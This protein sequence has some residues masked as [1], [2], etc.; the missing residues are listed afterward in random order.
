MISSSWRQLL[1]QVKLSDAEEK[2]VRNRAQSGVVIFFSIV[3]DRGI[4]SFEFRELRSLSHY[5][6]CKPD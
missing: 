6:R 2:D 5:Y 4:A 1:Q 3:T